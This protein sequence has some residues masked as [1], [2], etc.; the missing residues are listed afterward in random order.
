MG[1]RAIENNNMF[2]FDVNDMVCINTNTNVE[3][4]DKEIIKRRLEIY[5]A[6]T[7][8]I[9]NGNYYKIK[10]FSKD[11]SIEG[12]QVVS[13]DKSEVLITFNG[14]SLHNLHSF[15]RIRFKGLNEDGVYKNKDTNELFSGGALMH[16]GVN[17][18]KLYGN[19]S[20]NIICLKMI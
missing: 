10:N 12:W 13:K 11:N 5:N 9:S 4:T 8:I 6:N 20:G 19:Y 3:T 16:Y 15:K 2:R 18:S 1:I 7:G 14:L 17:I